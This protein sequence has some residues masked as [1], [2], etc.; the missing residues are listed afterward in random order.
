VAAELYR[1]PV[2]KTPTADGHRQERSPMV[3]VSYAR[4]DSVLVDRLVADLRAAEVAVWYDRDLTAG[5]NW[6]HAI[7]QRLTTAAAVIVVVTPNSLTSSYVAAEWALAVANQMRQNRLVIPVLSG[8]TRVADLP[9]PL[10]ALQVLSL[11]DDYDSAI[12]RL[13]A[14]LRESTAISRPPEIPDDRLQVI[15]EEAVNQVFAR[16]GL[17]NEPT[18]EMVAEHDLVD[19]QQVDPALI[20]VIISFKPSMEPVFEAIRQAAR[21]VGLRAE[22]VKDSKGDYRIIDRMLLLIRTARLIV[23]DLTYERPNVYFELGYARGLGKTVITIARERTRIHF[24]AHDWPYLPYIDSRPLERDLLERM[25]H[26]LT[27]QSVPGRPVTRPQRPF[28]TRPRRQ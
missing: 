4:Q 21:K 16:L 2:I 18:Q 23:A 24:D 26:E 19:S 7:S 22:R 13:A 6:R 12:A 9:E 11:D 8:G 10:Q 17:P 20:F 28:P 3:F 5:D 25:R 15:V 1:R 27:A 14:T